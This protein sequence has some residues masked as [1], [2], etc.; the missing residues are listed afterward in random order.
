MPEG[1]SKEYLIY[2]K[3][4]MESAALAFLQPEEQVKDLG[5]DFLPLPMMRHEAILWKEK[6]RPVVPRNEEGCYE[7]IPLTTEQAQTLIEDR[8]RWRRKCLNEHPNDLTHFHN[9]PQ[10]LQIDPTYCPVPRRRSWAEFQKWKGKNKTLL[11]YV[12]LSAKEP[13]TVTYVVN[14]SNQTIQ[15]LKDVPDITCQMLVKIARMIITCIQRLYRCQRICECSVHVRKEILCELIPAFAKQLK[16]TYLSP[17]SA[18]QLERAHAIYGLH[19]RDAGALC[20]SFCVKTGLIKLDMQRGVKLRVRKNRGI[21]KF[22]VVRASGD[23]QDSASTP[24]APFQPKSPTGQYLTQLLQSHPHLVPAAVE[25]ELEKLAENHSSQDSSAQSSSKSSDLVL[26]RRIAELKEQERQRALEEIIYTL[27]VQKFVESGISMVPNLESVTSVEKPWQI[28]V[29]ELEAVHSREV[30]DL[31]SQHMILVLGGQGGSEYLD[32]STFAQISNVRVGQV[33][34]A[35]IIYGYFLRR[36]FQRYQLDKTM[37]VL[38]SKAGS[39]EKTTDV[40]DETTPSSSQQEQMAAAAMFA[41]RGLGGAGPGPV[42]ISG[43]TP[44]RTKLQSYI[45][46][47]DKEMLQRIATVRTRE[48]LRVL[49]KHTE[50]LFGRPEVILS[51][52]GSMKI[53]KDEVLKISFAGLRHLVLEAIA[54]G[55]FLWDVECHVDASYAFV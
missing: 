34:A 47:V 38:P 5:H 53:A 12:V 46:S 30:L 17:A 1:P 41:L 19:N 54:F 23:N 25:Q 28:Q 55:S 14:T 20:S 27:I 4:V 39:G 50:A 18:R 43:P 32:Q 31:V 6:M 52:D 44:S 7:G 48:S 40:V 29:K 16:F 22:A 24:I 37:K 33:Y 13:P 42:P 3:K 26:Y 49:E 8:P 9:T 2:E 11:N 35:S 36:I 51:P 45:M 10:A 15:L 21:V